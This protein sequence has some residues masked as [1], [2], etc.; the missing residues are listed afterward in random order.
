MKDKIIKKI[1]KFFNNII[2]KKLFLNSIAWYI[3]IV[4]MIIMI[5]IIII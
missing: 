1:A 2:K 5:N 3:L 4:Y